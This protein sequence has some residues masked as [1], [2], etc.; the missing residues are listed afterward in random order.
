MPTSAQSLAKDPYR[1]ALQRKLADEII[2]RLANS[3]RRGGYRP[4]D[5]FSKLDADGSGRL[6]R[7]ELL[8]IILRFEP[9]LTPT[10]QDAIFQRFD[11]DNS[12]CVSW[13]EFWNTIQGGNSTAGTGGQPSLPQTLPPTTPGALL[14]PLQPGLAPFAPAQ[15]V[16]V[17]A[18]ALERTLH[19]QEL[20]HQRATA[21][22]V[23][24]RI[25]AGI[26]RSGRR[27]HDFITRLDARASTLSRSE[28]EQTLFRLEPNLSG[29]E[30]EAVLVRL[31]LD[32]GNAVDFLDFCRILGGDLSITIDPRASSLPEVP[33]GLASQELLRQVS[34]ELQRNGALLE[35]TFVCCNVW[36]QSKLGASGALRAAP[37]LGHKVR[38]KQTADVASNLEA[39]HTQG[40]Q[41]TAHSSRFTEA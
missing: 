40:N 20:Q 12:G 41:N 33:V 25:A 32:R 38:S 30:R 18:G 5:L 9:G 2:Q 13:S 8:S 1:E 16:G 17:Q 26:A 11:A 29:Y 35:E 24:R 6:S 27:P 39:D 34:S 37:P 3:L 28:V 36:R 19:P 10:E 21:E 31:G 23:I 22:E 14:A 4:Q 15:T 7:Q